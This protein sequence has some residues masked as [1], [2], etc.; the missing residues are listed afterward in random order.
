[1]PTSVRGLDFEDELET[2]YA[3]PVTVG[4]HDVV[5]INLGTPPTVRAAAG[6]SG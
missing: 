5:Q 6:R 1:M 3:D 2:T 4:E